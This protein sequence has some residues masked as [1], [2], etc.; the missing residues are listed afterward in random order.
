MDG[1]TTTRN[2]NHE[3]EDRELKRSYAHVLRPDSY[4]L[5]AVERMIEEHFVKQNDMHAFPRNHLLDPGAGY[6]LSGVCDGMIC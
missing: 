5:T 6:R 3:R 2:D 4:C 1:A